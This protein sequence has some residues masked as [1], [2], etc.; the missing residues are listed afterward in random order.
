MPKWI[1]DGVEVN[2]CGW[3]S[4][5]RACE[6]FCTYYLNHCLEINTCPFKR[7]HRVKLKD[8]KPNNGK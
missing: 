7:E 8:L 4:K 2:L 6:V 1:V 3:A 5:F